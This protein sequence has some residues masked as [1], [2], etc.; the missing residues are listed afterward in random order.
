LLNEKL[1]TMARQTISG[2]EVTLPPAAKAFTPLSSSESTAP[3]N[4]DDKESVLPAPDN[5]KVS[6]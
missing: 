1:G 4:I 6:N 5:C 3:D 2:V